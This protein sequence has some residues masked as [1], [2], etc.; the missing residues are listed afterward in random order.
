MLPGLL[1]WA[2]EDADAGL[3]LVREWLARSRALAR[4]SDWVIGTQRMRFGERLLGRARSR[5]AEPF[6]RSGYDRMMTTVAIHR[7]AILA[8]VRRIA[9]RYE[10]AGRSAEAEAWRTRAAGL[11]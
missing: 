6:L 10:A 1:R 2:R 8:A 9:D 7:P 5:E 4:E 11:S 3:P